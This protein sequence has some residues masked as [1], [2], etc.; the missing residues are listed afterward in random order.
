V[1]PTV[2]DSQGQPAATMWDWYNQDKQWIT[3]KAHGGLRLGF[4]PEKQVTADVKG[5]KDPVY[6][7]KVSDLTKHVLSHAGFGD[8]A[9]DLSSFEQITNG[10]NPE[11]SIFIDQSGQTTTQVLDDLLGPLGLYILF[12]PNGKVVLKRLANLAP[13]IIISKHWITSIRRSA[14]PAPFWKRSLGWSKSW[15]VQDDSALRIEHRHDPLF[16]EHAAFVNLEWRRASEERQ[17]VLTEF[18][19]A[20]D[21][22]QGTAMES[23]TDAILEVTRQLD[24]TESRPDLYNV[25]VSNIL[26]KVKPG[27]AVRIEYDRFGMD[28]GRTFLVGSTV[29]NLKSRDTQLNLWG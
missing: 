25:T 5:E 8:S 4:H 2:F 21:K 28:S 10:F 18:P 6:I 3:H 24:L 20:L 1:P 16:E 23:E 22:F 29:E 17:S 13:S 11:T 9:L 14:P 7:D 27:S 12:D 19:R 26:F 15:L